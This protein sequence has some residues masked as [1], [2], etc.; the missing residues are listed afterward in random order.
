MLFITSSTTRI[1]SIPPEYLLYTSTKG[2]VEQLTRMLAKELGA[3]NIT[4]NAVAPGAV[5]TDM[6]RY[7]ARDLAKGDE[8]YKTLAA[9][10]PQKRVAV[11]EDIAPIV[12]FLARDEAGW[13]NGQVIMVNGVRI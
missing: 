1:S 6:L 8:F 7:V 2:A 10:Q 3:R 5:E 12:A 9:G 4:V 13:V 11:P